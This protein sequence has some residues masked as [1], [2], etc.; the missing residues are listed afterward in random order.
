MRYFVSLTAKLCQAVFGGGEGG[1]FFAEGKA[2]VLR[3]VGGIVVE[4]RT[5]HG[6]DADFFD[7][8]AR[9]FD[10]VR[11][12][13]IRNVGHDVIRTARLEALEPCAD[14]NSEQTVT[15]LQIIGGEL[16]VVRIRRAER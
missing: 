9:E 15:A 14:Q 3:A 7:E 8:I 5:G 10:I 2:E 12:T 13:E 11:E 1:F 6:G 4:A 16:R